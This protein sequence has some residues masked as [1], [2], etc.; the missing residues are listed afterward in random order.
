[1]GIRLA[2]ASPS[3]KRT[4]VDMLVR[5][6]LALAL[7]GALAIGVLSRRLG[8]QTLDEPVRLPDL[9]VGPARSAEGGIAFTIRNV[10]EASAPSGHVAALLFDGVTVEEER[11]PARLAPGAS[12]ASAFS[13]ERPGRG[14]SVAIV[15]DW[16]AEI[17]EESEDNN[18]WVQ[19]AGGDTAAPTYVRRPEA[20]LLGRT[21]VGISWETD[22]ESTG[23]VRYGRASRTLGASAPSSSEDGRHHEALLEGLAPSST[24][25]FEVVA[26]DAAGNE[27]W[28]SR[29]S[30]DTPSSGPAREPHVA[31]ECPE[32]VEGLVLLEATTDAPDAERVEFWVAGERVHIDYSPPYQFPWDA[33]SREHGPCEVSAVVVTRSGSTAIAQAEPTIVEK[34]LE[35]PTVSITAPAPDANVSGKVKV[36]AVLADDKGL[37]AAYFKVDGQFEEFLPFPAKPKTANV[38]FQWNASG[39][40][41][42]RH[43]LSV[44]AYDGDMKTGFATRD[45]ELVSVP[46]TLPKLK[47]LKH[48]VKR[49]GNALRVT[50]VVQNVGAAHA[51]G[52][53][54]SDSLA[55]F[56]AVSAQEAIADYEASFYST[57]R[58]GSVAILSHVDLAPGQALTYAYDAVPVLIHPSP[59]T[60]S[61]GNQLEVWYEGKPGEEFRDT[62]SVPVPKTAGGETIAQAHA[63]ALASA[64]YLLVTNPLR[65]EYYSSAPRDVDALLASMAH[66]ALRA[67]GALGYL[68]SCG[69]GEAGILRG[70]FIK[71]GAWSSKLRP[72]WP[73]DGYLLL[74]GEA[75]IVPAWKRLAG[76]LYT[77]KGEDTPIVADYADYPYASTQGDEIYPELSIGR[78]IGND[79]KELRI[80]LET[81]IRVREKAAGYAFHRN[82]ALI[83]SGFER[84]IGGG[85]DPIDFKAEADAAASAVKATNPGTTV[86]RIHTPDVANFG[87]AAAKKLVVQALF[88]TTV[89]SK[90]MLFLAGHGSAFGLDGVG[91]SDVLSKADPFGSVNPVLYAASCMTGR[92]A[93]GVSFAESFLRREA[94]AYIG[95]TK[96]GL[97]T[98]APNSK[99]FY[100]RWKPGT[101]AGLALKYTKQSLDLSDTSQAYYVGIYHLFGDPK[102]G[103]GGTAGGDVLSDSAGSG[104][105]EAQDLSY[106]DVAVPDLEVIDDG[107]A[108]RLRVP[109]ARELAEP[110]LPALPVY[111]VERL[112]PEGTSVE[113]VELEGRSERVSVDGVSAD[114][115]G[116]IAT[117]GGGDAWDPVPIG[118]ERTLPAGGG[119]RW[120]VVKTGAGDLLAI[121]ILPV[122]FDPRSGA[123]EFWKR[124]RFRVETSESDLHI[125]SVAFA[126]SEWALG[127]VV[128]AEVSALQ[129]GPRLDAI[130]CATIARENGASIVEAL[131]LRR[132]RD[133]EGPASFSVQ[134]DSRGAP[135]GSYELRI[136]LRSPRGALLDAESASFQLGRAS[137]AT[138]VLTVLPLVLWP[139]MP[140]K[141][142]L[143]FANDGE[144]A[145]SGKAVVRVFDSAGSQVAHAEQDVGALAP[146]A[147]RR[148]EVPLETEALRPGRH[149]LRGFLLHD[150]T[151][152]AP[153]SAAL[154][155]VPIP[156]SLEL[157]PK[158][159]NLRD[160]GQWVTAFLELPRGIPIARL[161]VPSL[162]LQESVTPSGPAAIGD[163]DRDRIPD[164]MVKFDRASL[165]ALLERP[166]AKPPVRVT[167]VVTGELDDG[168]PIR[169]E[170]TLRIQR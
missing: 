15:A 92:Y 49:Q 63:S 7:A 44:E 3:R 118:G 114:I 16:H 140:A 163:H 113:A 66:L 127:G 47:I 81:S 12:Y 72:D 8:A 14:V 90:G 79:P 64:D 53:A 164:L 100:E 61:I 134:W 133:L 150:G 137:V 141:A 135:P 57:G 37:A 165:V 20:H 130:L 98:H 142:R 29:D 103:A 169:G 132:L 157:S 88:F 41:A 58:T 93:D 19:T 117:A 78:M 21:S 89:P 6:S 32:T 1:M 138:K 124:W 152:S 69:P 128:S 5:R 77:T 36:D 170:C 156:V 22:E 97:G 111:R 84:G 166:K 71:G 51:R 70:L 39:W 33:A 106:L 155:V 145:V 17:A 101:S 46:V 126:R 59:P 30:F 99:L 26:R 42:G 95:A 162:R 74:V 123:A 147:S 91:A 11:I 18:S 25:F 60:P 35:A 40:P 54:L 149:D 55:G 120:H 38:S 75:E 76:Y 23:E 107:L 160:R 43:R 96:W 73:L 48:E 159:L 148:V 2:Q 108:R 112:Y 167:I 144:C 56:Q 102:Y 31:L 24:Y 13:S 110:G 119:F 80:G 146:G 161:A 82:Q 27:A 116:P 45:V 109:G 121:H 68:V 10:G 28:S 67:E 85:A 52:I 168:R 9:V 122:R 153:L 94:G 151:A 50:V 62:C 86:N 105:G 83:L 154:R 115:V 4:E 34:D 139:G 136:E 131:P 143:C 158:T 87:D 125:A 104:G 65:L 129:R